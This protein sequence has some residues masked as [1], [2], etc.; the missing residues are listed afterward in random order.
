MTG[1]RR[2]PE[3]AVIGQHDQML[4]L[5]ETRQVHHRL[6]KRPFVPLSMRIK[7][8]FTSLKAIVH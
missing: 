5:A 6:R 3:M 7:A 4:E 2:V 8:H 1:P